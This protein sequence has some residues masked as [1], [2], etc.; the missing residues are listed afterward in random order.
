MSRVGCVIMIV[1]AAACGAPES[2]GVLPDGPRGPTGAPDAGIDAAMIDA[3]VIDAGVTDAPTDAGDPTGPPDLVE[4]CGG[5]APVTL[6]DWENCFQKRKCEWTVGCVSLNTYRDVADC[7]ASGDAVSGGRLAAERRD[8]NRAIAQG[9]AA[10]NQDAFAQCLIGTSA[11]RCNTALFD[12]ACLTRFTGKIDDAAGCYTD[13]DC[14]SP[15]AICK[16]TCTDAC[17]LGSCQPKFKVG[18]A[19]TT[20]T[21]CEPGL[22]CSNGFCIA[23]DID[24]PCSD[25]TDCDPDAFCDFQLHRCKPTLALGAACT[26]ILQCGGDTSCVGLSISESNPGHCLRNSQAGDPCDSNGLCHGNLFCDGS[27]TCRDLPVLGEACSALISCA[28][29]NTI[30]NSGVCVLRADVGVACGNQTCLPGL[31]CT[32]ALNDS[33][34]VCAARRADGAPCADPSHCESY[35]C[36][37]DKT[38]PGVCLPWKDTCP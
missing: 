7:I 32:S 9:R 27:G 10:I 33:K 36:S 24:T 22:Q 30:C 1:V 12:P 20:F 25:V 31:F 34:P 18:Q 29:A 8:R 15:D 35:L 37:G 11:T 3:A 38:K 5:K 21:S 19:C 2:S 13:I 17:C 26:D 6:D 14:V 28:G 4:I 16:S 23:G